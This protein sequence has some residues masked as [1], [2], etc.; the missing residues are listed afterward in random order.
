MAVLMDEN[1]LSERIKEERTFLHDVSGPVA[2][3]MLIAE[4]ISEDLSHPQIATLKKSLDK[5]QALLQKRR[6]HLINLPNL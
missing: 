5:I 2:T 4:L 1:V 3:C 6:E